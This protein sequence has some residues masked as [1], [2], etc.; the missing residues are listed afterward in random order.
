MDENSDDS[1]GNLHKDIIN[2]GQFKNDISHINTNSLNSNINQKSD[3]TNDMI[4][5]N[6]EI[7][8]IYIYIYIQIYQV[9]NGEVE[10][11]IILNQI[12]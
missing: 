10:T 5:N 12:N 4:Q 7:I 3:Y 9:Y 11:L 1:S 6:D 2:I 8:N